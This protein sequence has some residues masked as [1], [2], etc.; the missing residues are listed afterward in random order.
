MTFK[1]KWDSCPVV[2][3]L[4]KSHLKNGIPDVA[5]GGGTLF[6]SSLS[7]PKSGALIKSAVATS[8]TTDQF[9]TSCTPLHYSP[10]SITKITVPF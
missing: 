6:L 10:L 9:F 4:M 3:E 8:F 7:T 5:L 1:K 2:N